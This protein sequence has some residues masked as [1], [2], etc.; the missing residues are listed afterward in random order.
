MLPKRSVLHHVV[1]SRVATC[2]TCCLPVLVFDVRCQADSRITVYS[3]GGT[4]GTSRKRHPHV[5]THLDWTKIASAIEV[6][7]EEFSSTRT[8]RPNE[9]VAIVQKAKKT[10]HRYVLKDRFSMEPYAGRKN[11]CEAYTVIA[12]LH[13][14]A[15]R[16][17]VRVSV[18]RFNMSEDNTCQITFKVLPSSA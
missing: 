3:A 4:R 18:R 6:S 7:D 5:R 8:H 11:A 9:L 2:C 16:E 12:K 15:L 13:D 14:A 17:G 1:R 10:G